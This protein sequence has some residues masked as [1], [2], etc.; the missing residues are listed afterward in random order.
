MNTNLNETKN[1]IL[2]SKKYIEDIVGRK[3]KYFFSY[4]YGDF[5]SN[6]ETNE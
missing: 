2:N 4:P 5:N 6:C 3:V 1:E